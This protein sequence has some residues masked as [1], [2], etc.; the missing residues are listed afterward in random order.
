MYSTV[1]MSEMQHALKPCVA[2]NTRQGA[3]TDEHPRGC[4]A[5]RHSEPGVCA[6]ARKLG[7]QSVLM[8]LPGGPPWGHIGAKRRG[9]GSSGQKGKD[10]GDAI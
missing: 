10:R 4:D 2:A 7:F 9:A 8:D 3:M 5:W 1:N 6:A